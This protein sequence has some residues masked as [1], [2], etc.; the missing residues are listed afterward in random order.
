MK[1]HTWRIARVLVLAAVAAA[2]AFRGAHAQL[3]TPEGTVIHNVATASFTDANGNTYSNVQATADITVG[4]APGIDVTGV[5]S[6]TPAAPSTGNV[7]S[8]PVHNI[9][10]GTDHVS[11]SEAISTAGVITVANYRFNSTL[12]GTLAALNTAL[13]AWN[14]RQDTT[15][16]V[17][18]LYDVLAGQGGLTTTY[19]LTAASTRSPTTTDAQATIINPVVTRA[20]AVTPDGATINQVPTNGAQT[21]TQDF[22]VTNN[23]NGPETYNL[24]ATSGAVVTIVSVNGVNGSSTSLALAYGAAPTVAVV[25]T[26]ANAAA[27]ATD[28]LVLTA[29]AAGDAAVHDAGNLTVTVVKPNLG[30]TKVAYRDDGA[31]LIGGADRVLPGEYVRYLVTVTNSGTSPAASVVVTD[32]LP[33]QVTHDSEIPISG[34]WAFGYSAPTVTATLTG[35]LAGGSSVS[36]WIRVR[37]N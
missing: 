17:E 4:F 31:T 1:T 8:F 21:Y 26:V 11:V 10:N 34:T 36:F 6:V 35:T 25:Y 14:V 24:V 3:P 20:V 16:T 9:G 5:A 37:V 12:Y 28:N 30:M 2:F 7:L 27:G 22:T 23:G 15:I 18:V 29:T 13:A 33:A 32:D 19:T